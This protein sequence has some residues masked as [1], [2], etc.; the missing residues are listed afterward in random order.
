VTALS[1]TSS[2]F[3]TAA[4]SSKFDA[5][6]N[7]SIDESLKAQALAEEEA[8]LNQYKVSIHTQ[9]LKLFILT[10][11][12]HPQSKLSPTNS[13]GNSALTNPFLSSPPQSQ[14][15][16]VDLFSADISQP[17]Q[18]EQASKASDDL[19]QLGNPFADIF[20]SSQAP[21][22]AAAAPQPSNNMWMNGKCNIEKGR[23]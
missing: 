22:P 1:S 23:N 12:F 3:G 15:N 11:V 17:S 10:F 14:Q 5:H 18:Q 20:G 16:I 2:S 4:T 13:G 6:A 21:Q 7:G 19:L 9:T 8:A